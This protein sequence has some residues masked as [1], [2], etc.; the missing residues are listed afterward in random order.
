MQPRLVSYH[1]LIQGRTGSLLWTHSTEHVTSK[2]ITAKDEC[3]HLDTGPPRDV[4]I[5]SQKPLITFLYVAKRTLQM[6]LD[7][8]S[9]LGILCW[10][11]RINLTTGVLIKWRQRRQMA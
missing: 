4:D 7:L 9:F 5:E 6:S 1:T 10:I 11:M 8:A 3:G 2:I